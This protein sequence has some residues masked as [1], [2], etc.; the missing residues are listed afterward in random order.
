MTF[1]LLLLLPAIAWAQGMVVPRREARPSPLVK[2]VR[3]PPNVRFE[4]IAAQAGLKFTHV[5]GDPVNKQ[6]LV[7]STGSGVALLDFDNDGL[8]DIFLVNGTRWQRSFPAT[9]R[10][11]RNS[12]NLRFEDVTERANLLKRGWGQG[13]CAGD[14]DNDGFV[15]LFVTYYGQNVLYHNQGDGTFRDVT[16]EAGLS[17][18]ETRWSTGCAF[19]DYDRDGRLDLAVANYARLD[20]VSTLR[21]GAN[22]L[23]MYKGLPVMCGPR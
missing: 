23:C 10:L 15:D 2:A 11:Y 9:S 20:P 5:S 13:A 6:F 19:V 18:K 21:P 4:N 16:T 1:W 14:Y 3:K 12:G 7:E 22:P 17:S 8:L